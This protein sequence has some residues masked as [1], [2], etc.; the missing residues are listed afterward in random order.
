M[1]RT[2]VALICFTF[3]SAAYATLVTGFEASQG[4]TG[5][6]AGTL[7]PGQQSWYNPVAGSADWKVYTYAGNPYGV[8]SNPDGG[9]QFVG[10]RMEG[11]AAF[12]RGQ[13][14][15]NW[16][17]ETTL[18]VGYDFYAKYTGTLPATNN[19][20]SFS[21]QPSSAT[22]PGTQIYMQTLA[23][24]QDTAGATTYNIGFV[25]NEHTG[26]APPYF[27]GTAWQNI[28]VDH[29]IRQTVG[30][31]MTT[32]MILDVTIQDLTAGTPAVSAT[33]NEHLV[34]YSQPGGT[35]PTAF[36]FFTG[37]G[38]GSDPAGN[39][40]AYDNLSIPEPATLALLLIGLAALRRR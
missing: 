27:P 31:N 25:T 17:G 15:Y 23:Y 4:Y 9:E 1:K 35:M 7:L 13:H 34:N 36:R 28:P 11:L 29:W 32:K 30:L 8:V 37:G 3:A 20:G 39:F 24:W 2:V 22:I 16:S 10:G 40:T 26:T 6:A 19:L 5:S 18:T 14:D 38:A 33:L 12:A 21:L